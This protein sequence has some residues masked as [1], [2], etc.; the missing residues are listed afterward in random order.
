MEKSLNLG[1]LAEEFA[2]LLVDV[3]EVV[4]PQET[5]ELEDGER[6]DVTILFLDLIGYTSLAERLD[7]EQLKFVISNTLQVFT[8]QI[9]KCGGTVEKYVGDAI[10]ALF[11]RA[12]AHEDDSRRAVVAARAILDKLEDINSILAQK[13]IEISARIGINRG[14]VV[15][16]HLGGHDTVTGEAINIAQRLEA[17]APANGVLISEQIYQDCQSH[18]ACEKLPPLFVKNKTEPLTVYLIQEEIS[19]PY[20]GSTEHVGLFVGREHEL[21]TLQVAWDHAMRGGLAIVQVLGE[22]GVGK[23]ALMHAFLQRLREG[24]HAPLPVYVSVSSFGMSPYHALSDLVQAY[25][26]EAGVTV[27]EVLALTPELQPYRLYLADLLAQDLSDDERALLDQMEPRARQAETLLAVKRL[28]MSIAH[29][30]QHRGVGPLVVVID[31]VQWVTHASRDAMTQI[32][33]TLDTNLPLLWIFIGRGEDCATWV[34]ARGSMAVLTV[35]PLPLA[36]VQQLLRARLPTSLPSDAWCQQIY[37]RTGGNALFLHEVLAELT[38]AEAMG[39]RADEMQLPASIKALVLSRTDRLPRH[40]KFAL[41]IAAVAA[42][43]FSLRCLQHIFERVRY[44]HEAAAV[45]QELLDA[46]L[47]MCVDEAVMIAQPMMAE[48]AYSTILHTNRHKLHKM[49]A[50]WVEAQPHTGRSMYAA[51]LADQ[52]ER[53]EVPVKAFQY[54]LEAGEAA[55]RRYAHRDAN[56]FFMRALRQLEGAS[57]QVEAEAQTQLY[58]NLALLYEVFGEPEKWQ[59]YIQ[60][61]LRRTAPGSAGHARL[62]LRQIEAKNRYGDRTTAPQLLDEF[63]SSA[64]AQQHPDICLRALLVQSSFA[65]ERGHDDTTYIEAALGMRAQIKD[66]YLLYLLDNSVFNHYK[67][68]DELKRAEEFFYRVLDTETPNAYTKRLSD[69]FFCSFMWD[70][71][72]AFETIAQRAEQAQSY[73]REVGWV[74]GLGW[75]AFYRGGALWRLGRFQAAHTV[76][77]EA[78]QQLG[79]AK[80][81]FMVERLELL[82]AGVFLSRGELVEYQVRKGRILERVATQADTDRVAM[83][84]EFAMFEAQVLQERHEL[85]KVYEELMAAG[86]TALPKVEADEYT[87]SLAHVCARLGHLDEAERLLARVREHVRANEKRWLAGL[88]ARVEGL[89]AAS[90]RQADVAQQAFGESV[91]ILQQL[92]AQF[93]CYLTYVAWWKAIG[94]LG[95]EKSPAAT[96]VAVAMEQY[97]QWKPV[98]R[99]GL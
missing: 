86:T 22:A 76:I 67:N 38:R 10:M 94:S 95:L 72:D 1:H 36:A 30:R 89:I 28:L 5:I 65:Q 46:K 59:F 63:V 64:E 3:P 69:L 54:C 24:G 79:R 55:R 48:V 20:S 31:N 92:H 39:S 77:T 45:L 47:V 9:K 98:A 57:D 56:T 43:E 7:P 35:E 62:R 60:E 66:P 15:T 37:Q 6:R 42:R 91:V 97:T 75:G 44:T 82:L 40:Q 99:N 96:Q 2:K 19:T 53:A 32:L 84:R 90:R 21:G 93:E 88:L 41:Q 12:E 73:F 51:Y 17:N 61:G 74:R 87:I 11:G 52:W 25:L 34:P 68:A 71:G 18:Y 8:N 80:D 23:T 78:L 70:R 29:Q 50:Q 83:R 13:D 85:S 33:Q 16:G 49:V 27:T 81:Q 26:V 58:T 4:S 14:L